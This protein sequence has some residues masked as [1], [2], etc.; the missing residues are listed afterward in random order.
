M[1]DQTVCRLRM[2]GSNW[3]NS[4]RP[5]WRRKKSALV[6]KTLSIVF[7]AAE[8]YGRE[9]GERE[10]VR[11]KDAAGS[12]FI[13]K[14]IFFFKINQLNKWSPPRFFLEQLRLLQHRRCPKYFINFH[15]L[16]GSPCKALL[17]QEN[18]FNLTIE[19]CHTNNRQSN[20]FEKLCIWNQGNRAKICEHPL[21]PWWWY[22][23]RIRTCR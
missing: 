19:Q 22:P 4:T 11:F 8:P 14:E 18:I 2:S 20:N 21:L 3:N 5:D 23:E 12:R 10:E 15:I 6:K 13:C 1:R 7:G 16:I 9:D 17:L